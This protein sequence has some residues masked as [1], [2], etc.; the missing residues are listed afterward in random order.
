MPKE[1]KYY[2]TG[3]Q[4]SL[5]FNEN[6]WHKGKL[7]EGDEQIVISGSAENY[8]YLDFLLEVSDLY[9]QKGAQ[10]TIAPNGALTCY[11][12]SNSGLIKLYGNDINRGS[13]IFEEFD[14]KGK[15]QYVYQSEAKEEKLLALP[16]NETSYSSFDS[17]NIW[18]YQSDHWQQIQDTSALLDCHH[19]YKFAADTAKPIQFSG[20]AITENMEFSFAESG[21]Q[22][23]PNPYT[24]SL[25]WDDL[26]LYNLSHQ[27]LYRFIEEDSSFV[28]YV[29]GLGS[30]TPL[31]QPLDV[32]WVMAASNESVELSVEDRMHAFSF[33]S[34]LDTTFKELVIK[35]EGEGGSDFTHI[36]FNPKATAAFDERLDAYKIFITNNERPLVFTY[37][38][39]DLLSINQL[40]DTTMLDMGVLGEY[41]TSF[42]L[43]IDENI[44]FDFVVLEDLILNTKTDLLQEDY[45]FDYFTSDGNYP[46][47]LYFKDWVLQPLEEAD[48]EIYYYPESVVVRSKKQVDVAEI[49]FFDLAGRV[50]EQYVARNFFVF[51]KPVDLP[52]GHYIVQL[53]TSD[54]VV[55]KKILVRK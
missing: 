47:K 46:F 29:D 54:L 15:I 7:P 42:K 35:V 39:D 24:A 50:A 14:E 9:I 17:L 2:W 21:L 4:D 40:P 45:S 51:E 36:R 6:N 44:N 48:V 26:N 55:N 8:P 49:T 12:L 31:V 41:N 38:E 37:A 20:D 5:W 25:N 23:I 16:V 19:I 53:R 22:A 28:S 27:A 13:L 43:S 11:Q 33:N 18:N 30:S 1:N 52:T 32:V 3:N 34:S 10:I